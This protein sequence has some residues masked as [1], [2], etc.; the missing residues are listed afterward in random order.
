MRSVF[1]ILMMLWPALGLAQD[2][3]LLKE[4][5]TVA[6][7]RHALAPGTGDPADFVLDD[8]A[9]QRNLDALGRDQ[10]RRIGEAMRASDVTFDAVWS[11]QW[12]RCLETAE[13]LAMGE[14]VEVPS[15]NSHFAGR[16]DPEAQTQ[17][18]LQT[19]AELPEDARVL[20]VTHQVN[21]SALSGR[22]ASSGEIVVT[23]RV[24]DRLQV[25]G[26]ILLDP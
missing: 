14:I 16:G 5:G 15:L 2:W 24:S 6:L 18:T 11:S 22:P 12:C 26:T 17:A 10:A 20:L 3:D 13:L 19:I 8:C 23:R 21:V 1:V 9:T 4:P 25:V 7:M